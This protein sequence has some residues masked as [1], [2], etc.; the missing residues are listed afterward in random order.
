MSSDEASLEKIYDELVSMKTRQEEDKF[1]S[2]IDVMFA[3]LV[4]IMI[5]M[6]GLIIN[7]SV[8]QGRLNLPLL[9]Y[10]LSAVF[11]FAIVLIG[12]FIAILRDDVGLRFFFWAILVNSV[13]QIILQAVAMFLM[14]FVGGFYGSLVWWPMTLLGFGLIPYCLIELEKRYLGRFSKSRRIFIPW[15]PFSQRIGKPDSRLFR[16]LDFVFMWMAVATII[17][18]P[19]YV[20]M[21]FLFFG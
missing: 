6:L 17:R 2:K 3:T 14:V 8:S 12:E 21:K 9:F 11:V 13:F 19:Q 15:H 16:Y 1:L 10:G 20:L 4:S 18:L 7:N 5:F